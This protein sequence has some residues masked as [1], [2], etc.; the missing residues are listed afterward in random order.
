MGNSC[1]VIKP[2]NNEYNLNDYCIDGY[3]L[4][5]SIKNNGKTSDIL[6]DKPIFKLYKIEESN[7][8][9]NNYNYL[10]NFN[11]DLTDNQKIL[12][13]SFISNNKSIF[14]SF[15]GDKNKFNE[16]ENKFFDINC[17]NEYRNNTFKIIPKIHKSNT[18]IKKIIKEKPFIIGKELLQ[19]YKQYKNYFE[20]IID[21][22]SQNYDINLSF[23][24]RIAEIFELLLKNSI[25][26]IGSI[27]FSIQNEK[28]DK[29]IASCT[30]NHCDLRINFYN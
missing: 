20:I 4:D 23:T 15:I 22:D 27:G 26:I 1:L 8:K 17:S 3:D 2:T 24:K 18:L 9:I 5:F 29:I 13:I 10:K 11:K 12:I 28:P 25:N 30:F 19:T 6:K 14:L 7:N 16:D 21:I